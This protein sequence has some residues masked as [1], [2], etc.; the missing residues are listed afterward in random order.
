MEI[1]YKKQFHIKHLEQQE[2]FFEVKELLF[3]KPKGLVR[4]TS[5]DTIEDTAACYLAAAGGQWESAPVSMV[6]VIL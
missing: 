6:F 3:T 4:V 5:K 1:T 2:D